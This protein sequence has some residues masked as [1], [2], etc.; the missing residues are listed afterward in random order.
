ML[1]DTKDHTKILREL[2]RVSVLLDFTIILAWSMEETGR[3]IETFKAYETKSADSIKEKQATTDQDRVIEALTK[4][5]SVNK[6]DATVLQTNLKSFAE[7]VNVD[8][9][10]LQTLPG[11]GQQ[12]IRRI[13]EAFDEPFKRDNK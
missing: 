1:V 7:I 4:I 10:T 6:T 13:L 11:F 2:T 3:Y 5:S 12:K 9:S 8:K